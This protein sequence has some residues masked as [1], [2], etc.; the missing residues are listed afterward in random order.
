MWQ[1]EMEREGLDLPLLIGGATTSR[2][3]TA[4][5]IHPGYNKGQTV[6]VTDASRAVGVVSALLSPDARDG[7]VSDIRA[8]YPRLRTAHARSEAEK[9]RLPLARARENAHKVDWTAYQPGK[10]SFLGTKV[11]EDYDLATLAEYIDWTPFFQTWELKGRYPAIL[12]DEKQGE[13]ARA[14]LGRCAGDAEED[15]RRKVVPPARR[16]RLLAGGCRRRRYQAVHR[17]EPQG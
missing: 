13:A 3:H 5:K 16:H 14:A 9:Q 2:V 8:E 15:H 10:P 4:V 12:E 6:Y 7:Y 17:R 1:A 11:F